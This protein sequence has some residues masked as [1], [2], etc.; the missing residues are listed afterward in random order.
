MTGGCEVW[1]VWRARLCR[2]CY[3]GRP[4]TTS[5]WVHTSDSQL[6][7][8]NH[9]MRR[10]GCA[11]H[12]HAG[13]SVSPRRQLG[14]PC[15]R[16]HTHVVCR[17]S[18]AI[19][20]GGLCWGGHSH[21]ARL[22]RPTQLAARPSNARHLWRPT[23]VRV[24][25]PAAP[26]LLTTQRG[27]S[28]PCLWRPSASTARAHIVGC[29]TITPCRRTHVPALAGYARACTAA[30]PRSCVAAP[31]HWGGCC[32]GGTEFGVRLVTPHNNPTSSGRRT[33]PA[34]WQPPPQ[35]AAATHV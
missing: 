2:W 19:D 26:Q 20:Y 28:A 31:R 27:T 18:H 30:M 12:R 11:S 35:H 10:D 4:P 23:I 21:H 5:G 33:T 7:A 13:A 6:V 25:G 15:A 17:S 32:R 1:H 22:C 9:G 16:A 8:T 24:V 3:A 34:R 14:A 29:V